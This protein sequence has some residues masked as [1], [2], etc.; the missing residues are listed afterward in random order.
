MRYV[1]KAHGDLFSSRAAAEEAIRR[2]PNDWGRAVGGYDKRIVEI[3]VHE[4]A[5][6]WASWVGFH[7][8][9]TSE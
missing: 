1:Y 7:L 5:S 4:S 2:T 6:S 9:E 3:R 8:K